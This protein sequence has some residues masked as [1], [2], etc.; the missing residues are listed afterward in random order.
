MKYLQRSSNYVTLPSIIHPHIIGFRHKNFVGRYLANKIEVTIVEKLF[1][2][3]AKR[4]SIAQSEMFTKNL[5]DSSLKYMLSG[6]PV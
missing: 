3:F 1:I 5:L 6:S 4:E 2:L